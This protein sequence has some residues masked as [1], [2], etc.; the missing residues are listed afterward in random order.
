MIDILPK[1]ELDPAL[2]TDKKI[3]TITKILSSKVKTIAMLAK[4]PNE[5]EPDE[6][7]M[8]FI[9]FFH[10]PSACNNIPSLS[11]R[12]KSQTSN[13]II[14]RDL[15]DFMDSNK[16]TI[17]NMVDNNGGYESIEGDVLE[18]LAIEKLHSPESVEILGLIVTGAKVDVNVLSKPVNYF[19][20]DLFVASNIII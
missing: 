20:H 8:A 6:V 16:S 15:S 9:Q 10:G 13:S 2:W 18:M 1:L 17:F 14:T 19:F 11:K 5:F 3:K 12:L 4:K 7:M